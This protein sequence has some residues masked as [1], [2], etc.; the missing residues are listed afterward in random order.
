MKVDIH[1]WMEGVLFFEVFFQ[2]RKSLVFLDWICLFYNFHAEIGNLVFMNCMF[3]SFSL[4]PRN[5]FVYLHFLLINNKPCCRLI[6]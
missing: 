3:G 2:K 1:F 5:Q 6:A 4:V